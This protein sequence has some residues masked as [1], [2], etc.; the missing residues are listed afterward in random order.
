LGAIHEPLSKYKHLLNIIRG[1]DSLVGQDPNNNGGPHQRGIGSLFTGQTLL[2]GEFTDG[3]GRAAGWANGISLDQLVAG[4]IGRS[5]PFSSLELGVRANSNDVQ[6]R[7]SY[8]GAG[9]PLPPINDP[10][11]TYERLFFGTEPLDPLDPNSRAKGVLD[12]LHEQFQTLSPQV[13]MRDREK[14]DQHLALVEDLERRLTLSDMGGSSASDVPNMRCD[15]VEAPGI[16]EPDNEETMPAVSRAQ[17]DLLAA[18]FT[19]DLTRVASVQY[20]TGFNRIRYPWLDDE[21]EG[22]SLSHSGDGDEPAWKALTGRATWHAG[23]IAYFMDRLAEVPE[24]DGTLLDNTL[25]LWGN[26]ISKGNSHSLQSIPYLLIGNAQGRLRSGQYLQF[27]QA[28]NCDLL[29]T[30][31]LACGIDISSFGRQDYFSGEL[32]GLL[33]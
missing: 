15:G 22:H 33:A 3:C 21:G 20:S 10:R 19:C 7:I 27:S 2:E 1:V 24:G 8:A 17:L 9:A 18:A 12:T 14:L 25:I 11:A 23:E 16:L 5:T 31:A 28:S 26:E 29:Y 6:G 4:E 30:V 32:P 13:S